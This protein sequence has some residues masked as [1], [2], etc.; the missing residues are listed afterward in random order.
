M[1]RKNVTFLTLGDEVFTLI[2]RRG[3]QNRAFPRSFARLMTLDNIIMRQYE[4]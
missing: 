2:F 4:C 3:F 1:Q